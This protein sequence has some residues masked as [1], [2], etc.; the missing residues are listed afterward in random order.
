MVGALLGIA[1]RAAFE[2]RAGARDRGVGLRLLTGMVIELH[3]SQPEGGHG[4]PTVGRGRAL[5]E[6]VPV[7]CGVL[8]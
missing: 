5:V 1:G 6:P 2:E 4:D 8:T 7:P 3:G